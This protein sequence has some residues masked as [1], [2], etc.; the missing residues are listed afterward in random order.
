MEDIIDLGIAKIKLKPVEEKKIV[1]I[2]K[3]PFCERRVRASTRSQ[4]EWNIVLHVK[5]KHL[6]DPEQM[7]DA[8][9]FVDQLEAT[10]KAVE[11]Y[12]KKR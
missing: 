4:M 7:I 8:K 9:V 5:Q 11:E 12:S 10:R 6:N 2:A 3:C 1:L